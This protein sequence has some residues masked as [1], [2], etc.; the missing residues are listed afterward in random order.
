VSR[1]TLLKAWEGTQPPPSHDVDWLGWLEAGIEMVL[2]SNGK[3]VKERKREKGARI[4]DLQHKTRLAE[5]QLQRDPEDEPVKNILSVAQGH[6]ANSLQEQVARNHQLSAST[7]FRYG[8]T[9]SKCFFDFHRI[10]RTRTLLKE[11]ATEDGEIKVKRTWL[12]TYVPSTHIS[13]PR[14]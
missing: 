7:W 8:D 4:R 9:C 10:G 3:L 1:A 14:K 5:I 12:T 13:T 11:L 6:L 2:K